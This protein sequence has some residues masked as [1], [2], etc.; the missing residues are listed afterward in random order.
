MDLLVSQVP[1]SGGPFDRLRAGFRLCSVQ[2]RVPGKVIPSRFLSAKAIF[3][4]R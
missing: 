4:Q 3:C 2:A 1:E